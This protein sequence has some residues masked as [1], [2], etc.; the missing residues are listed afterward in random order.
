[1]E[2]LMHGMLISTRNNL[3]IYFFCSWTLCELFTATHW[4]SLSYCC[5]FVNAVDWASTRC[6]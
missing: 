6:F 4:L 3:Q 2:T 1:V 5:Q